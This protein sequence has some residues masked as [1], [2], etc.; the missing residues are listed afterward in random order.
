MPFFGP[1]LR[2]GPPGANG[3]SRGARRLRA[4]P[5]VVSGDK[6]MGGVPDLY[7]G[8]S[9]SLATVLRADCWAADLVEVQFA[10]PM[11]ND[12]AL[13]NA[14]E[15]ACAAIDGSEELAVRRV[16]VP[17]AEEYP[18]TAQIFLVVT[19][20]RDG[21]RYRVSVDTARVRSHSGLALHPDNAQADF[22]GRRTQI[23]DILDTRQPMMTG[24]PESNHRMMLHAILRRF[25]LI[26]GARDDRLP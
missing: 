9:L 2:P 20:F 3:L 19:A 11:R 1:P 10:Q 7:A 13:L 4:G 6:A 5:V 21:V 14:D 17:H 12:A 26:G 18:T 16:L 15:Y 25:D 8:A 23:D 22:F 24:R